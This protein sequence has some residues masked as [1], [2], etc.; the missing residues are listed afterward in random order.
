MKN[1][2]KKKVRDAIYAHKDEIFH[3]ADSIAKEP[4]L[5]F[6]EFKTAQK[7]S[8]FFN[9]HH[10]DYSASHAITGVKGRLKG[11]ASKR[12]VAILGELDAIVCHDHPLA[13][14][15]TGAAHACGHNAQIAAMLACAIGLKESGVID[16][17][18]GDVV[19]FAVP[20]EEYVELEYRNRLRQQGKLKYFGGKAELIRL[21]A[22]D[23]IDMAMMMHVSMSG[24]NKRLIDVG[25]TSNGFVGKLVKFI[26]K[27]AHAAGAPHEG[28]NAL[29]AA[30]IA[31]TAVHAQRETFKDEDY[32]RFHPIITKGGDLVNVV[33]S[34]IRME[35]YVRAKTVDAMLDANKKVNRALKG[36]AMAIGAEVE[37]H[38]MPGFLPLVNDDKM[39]DLFETNAIDILGENATIHLGHNSG[40]TDMGDVS[41]IMPIIHPWMGGVTG[42]VHTRDFKV[43]DPE[44]AYLISAECMAAT[45]ID[46][47][48]DNAL[49]AEQVL[50]NYQPRMTKEEYLAFME[51]IK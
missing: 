29:N 13:D 19:A 16:E 12:T 47:L 26:G 25:G 17:L 48:Y 7:V 1:L 37:I 6:K 43:S 9:R 14:L 11:K 39:T 36:G 40:S 46:L 23:D 10:I 41:H 28:I 35:S 3:L 27:E 30:L 8:D 50:E 45:I 15:T 31:L 34:E 21:G 5:G 33:P 22:F 18:D 4:E 44:M 20:A 32:V 51:S 42:T 24:E 49:E 2:L 38:D